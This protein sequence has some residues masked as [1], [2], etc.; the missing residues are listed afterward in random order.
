MAAAIAFAVIGGYADA[1]GFLRYH[2][3]AGMMTGN[4]VLMGLA[5]FRRADLPAWDYAG[6]L[7]IFFLAAVAAFLLLRYL[8]PVL[9]LI[10]EAVLILLADGF[11]GAAWAAIFLVA[12]MGIQN[13]V[14]ARF[15]LAINTTFITGDILR[16]AEGLTRRRGD[17]D[18]AVREGFAIFGWV[19][20]A[21][22]LGA[23]LGVAAFR[24]VE[25]PLVLPVVLLGFV[26]AWERLHPSPKSHNRS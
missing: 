8:P 21:Y 13:P 3:F 9:L 11:G 4:T 16:F 25:R 17:K 14:G 1:I 18:P 12:A 19:W 15:G 20:L 22:A 24:L 6:L 5:L 26:Y 10:G 7:A 2:A 23:A